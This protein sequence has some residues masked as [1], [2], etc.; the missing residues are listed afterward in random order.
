ME[1]M[2]HQRQKMNPVWCLTVGGLWLGSAAEGEGEWLR[3]QGDI[4]VREDSCVTWAVVSAGLP[5][6]GCA[7]SWTLPTEEAGGPEEGG[8]PAGEA[9]V[10]SGGLAATAGLGGRDQTG[11]GWRGGSGRMGS[12]RMG[13]G[14]MGSSDLI[15]Y[16]GSAGNGGQSI[17]GLLFA[18]GLLN[19]LIGSTEDTHL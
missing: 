11:F 18:F 5:S 13:S 17:H 6:W 7:R 9:G 8:A 1:G 15:G 12:G 14:R 4:K 16:R 2:K 19:C 10:G 3:E